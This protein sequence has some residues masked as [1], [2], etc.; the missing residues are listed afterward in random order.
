[1]TH[2][3]ADSIGDYNH[4]TI[5]NIRHNLALR[6]KQAIDL[7]NQ[8]RATDSDQQLQTMVAYCNKWDAVY[9]FD[10]LEYYPEFDSFVQT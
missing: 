6:I 8:P 5:E 1:M 4:R 9:K 3:M 2:L 7:L 10:L